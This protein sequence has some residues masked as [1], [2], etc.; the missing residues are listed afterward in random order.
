MKNNYKFWI[1]FSFI[2]VFVIGVVGGIFLE[3]HLIQAKPKK[4]KRERRAVHFPTLE[5][6]AK[7]L[8]LTSEQEEKIRE[9][10]KNN[11]GRLKNLKSS[12][13]ERLSNIRSQLKDEIKNVL[14]KEQKIQFEEMI[15][16]YIQQR[17]KE[18]E[19]RKKPRKEKGDGK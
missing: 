4:I 2:L 17:K 1:I 14:N 15:E 13:H 9:I 3:K 10:F 8:A 6:M 11:E 12:I 7:E 19:K 18:V 16:R 5:V